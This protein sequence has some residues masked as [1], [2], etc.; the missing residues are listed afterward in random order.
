MP[1]R[2]AGLSF[3]SKA[4]AANRVRNIKEAAQPGAVLTGEDLSIVLGALQRHPS[5]ASKVGIGVK[6]IRVV[7]NGPDL[8]GTGFEIERLD[9]T[10]E[11]FSY[12]ICFGSEQRA[13]RD[14][15][16][17]AFRRAVRPYIFRWSQRH[18]ASNGGSLECPLTGERVTIG[19]CHVDHVTPF[20]ALMDAFLLA[21]GIGADDIAYDTANDATTPEAVLADRELERRWVSFHNARA[22][23]RI[24]SVRGHRDQHESE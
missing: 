20:Q 10:R 11:R 8:A 18:F 12:R 21:E 2:L 5:C 1:V 23:L 6:A 19:T 3:P 22:K 24:V 15:L 17:E 14:R 4:A 13:A 9:G 16:S 7:R